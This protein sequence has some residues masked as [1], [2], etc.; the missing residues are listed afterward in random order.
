MNDH[1]SSITLIRKIFCLILIFIFSLTTAA[2]KSSPNDEDEFFNGSDILISEE[3]QQSSQ[4][5]D[6][7]FVPSYTSDDNYS[8][9]DSS[10]SSDTYVPYYTSENNYSSNNSSNSSSSASNSNVYQ[11]DKIYKQ[12][13]KWIVEGEWELTINKVFTHYACN[14]FCTGAINKP[15]LII[16]FTFKNIGY[17]H[18][19]YGNELSF[20][21]TDFDVYDANGLASIGTASCTH[22][23]D[24]ARCIP[25]TSANE[26]FSTYFGTETDLSK[27]KIKVS[28]NLSK[29]S[30]IF[31]EASAIFEIP[32]TKKDFFE[33]QEKDSTSSSSPSTTPAPTTPKEDDTLWTFNEAST[34]FS[35]AEYANKNAN[36]AIEYIMEGKSIKN[37]SM[38]YAQYFL[39][40]SC[41]KSAKRNLESAKNLVD[42]NKSLK[43][44]DGSTVSAM[45]STAISACDQVISL[46]LDSTNCTEQEHLI[47]SQT[48]FTKVSNNSLAIMN[49]ANQLMQ[50]F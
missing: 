1:I 13:E 30:S 33:S 21:F 48:I 39:A 26:Q 10:N 9:N 44:E 4:D 8:S 22:A 34:L 28:Q 3:S 7:T 18:P 14:K 2:C 50:E 5:S 20:S 17:T 27:V 19:K 29:A 49:A 31:D 35:Y 46:S 40:Q 25:G 37:P 38:K 6:G 12:G 36:K 11:D 41:L 42:K 43:F 32:V 16:D 24:G 15:V 45:I 23:Q 47:D